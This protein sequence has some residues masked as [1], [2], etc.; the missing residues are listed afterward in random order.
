MLAL[1]EPGAREVRTYRGELPGRLVWPPRGL[2]RVMEGGRAT[3]LGPWFQPDFAAPL[4]YAEVAFE[5]LVQESHRGR[6][7]AALA[8]AELSE[9]ARP[10][11]RR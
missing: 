4:T 3:S 6:A 1:A 8:A 10:E 9:P 2:D 5:E 11:A 7:F